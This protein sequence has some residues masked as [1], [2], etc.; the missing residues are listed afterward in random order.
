MKLKIA[1]LA[2]FLGLTNGISAQTFFEQGIIVTNAGDTLKG[3]IADSRND[4][5]AKGVIFKAS[6]SD[7]TQQFTPDDLKS[8]FLVP[9][10]YFESHTVSVAENRG[11][12]KKIVRRFLQRIESGYASLYKLSLT[13]K[14]TFFLKKEGNTDI[15]PF[16]ETIK[17][18]EESGKTRVDTL[19][20]WNKNDLEQDKFTSGKEHLRLLAKEFRDWQG[21]QPQLAP[22]TETDLKREVRAYNR[23]MHADFHP[24]NI[25]LKNKKTMV[26]TIGVN[27]F[28]ALRETARLRYLFQYDLSVNSISDPDNFSTFEVLSPRSLGF[29]ITTGFNGIG[30]M[31]G[32]SIELGYG[33]MTASNLTYSINRRDFSGKNYVLEGAFDLKVRNFLARSSYLVATS[34][35]FSPYVGA[36]L[37]IQR[38]ESMLTEKIRGETYEKTKKNLFVNKPIFAPSLVL[39]GQFAFSRQHALRAEL[40]FAIQKRARVYQTLVRVGY[41]FRLV[42]NSKQ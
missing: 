21:Y 25:N 30:S 13:G 11:G 12:N 42:K 33:Q 16:F 32:I 28:T 39:G 38:N 17:Y 1:I 4:E 36:A 41:Q 37:M 15:I 19:T 2:T 14:S 7:S 8:F 24:K 22:L 5:L 18:I 20:E 3:L 40:D 23:A 9:N 6:P 35:R 10:Q 26:W 31:K 34:T 29:E 27:A